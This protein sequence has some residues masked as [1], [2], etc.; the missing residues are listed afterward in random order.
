[1]SRLQLDAAV[2]QLRRLAGA[3]GPADLSD[4]Q[5]LDAFTRLRDEGAFATLVSRYSSLVMGVCRRALGHEQDAE[6][7]LQATFLVLARHAGAIRQPGSLAAFLHGVSYRVAMN[8]KRNLA[9]QRHKE[10]HGARSE[11]TPAAEE[12]SW[13]EVQALLDEEVQA[14]PEAFRRV[15]VLCCL[16]GL[17]KPEA[18]RQLGLKEGTVSSRLARA[19]KHLQERLEQRGVTLSTLMAA[20]DLGQSGARVSAATIRSTAGWAVAYAAGACASSAVPAR[21]AALADG[22]SVTMLSTKTKL[23][24][25]LLLL[26][27]LTAGLGVLLAPL[28]AQAP[29]SEGKT[30]TR[31]RK[32]KT[33]AKK[34]AKKPA[35][36]R[37]LVLDPSGNPVKGAGIYRV[38]RWLQGEQAGQPR[39]P[40]AETDAA[41]KFL[42]RQ[43]PRLSAD[44]S[45]RWM[46]VAPGF[47]PA[48]L[49][50]KAMTQTEVTFRLVKDEPVAGRVVSLEGKP[51]K[52]VTV[53][54][55]LLYVAAR[56][57]L[58]PCL[59]YLEEKGSKHFDDQFAHRVATAA[60]IPGLPARLTTDTAGR[61]RLSGVGRERVVGLEV[62]GPT[63]ETDFILIVT[64]SGKPLRVADSR[65]R[66]FPPLRVF[67]AKFDYAASP[68]Q[69]LVGTVRD[70][71]TG[72]PTAG[73]TIRMSPL[74]SATTKK[75]GTYRL[76]SVPG[77][78]FSGRVPSV[79]LLAEPPADQPYLPAVKQVRRGRPG[80]AMRVDFS[81]ARGVWAEG[82]VIDKKT[83]KPVRASITY[84]PD[85]RN[86][87]LKK[88]LDYEGRHRPPTS[89]QTRADG[90]FRLPVLL[91]PGVVAA[92]VP[93]HA[94]LEDESLSEEQRR[95]LV[96]P[97]G[98][99]LYAHAIA[100][101]D[102]RP[103]EVVKCDLRVDPGQTLACTLVDPNGKPVKGAHVRGL[104]GL[105]FWTSR[106]VP[107]AGLTFLALNPKKS[108]WVLVLHQAR[109]LGASLHI[110]PGV[111]E[112]F[113]IRLEPTATITG[114][115]LD[116]E[117]R[118][119]KRQELLVEYQAPGGNVISVHLPDVVRSDDEGRF[120]IQGLIPGLVYRISLYHAPRLSLGSA[121]H[122]LT[123]KSAHTKNVGDVKARPR[124]ED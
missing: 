26:A 121:L 12:L 71:A 51:I 72:K 47:G 122:G 23:T 17:S 117:G 96:M 87:Q 73:V 76:P 19:R 124:R 115:L 34:D 98:Y 112:P 32:E 69:P 105:D 123:L 43:A 9:R 46:A 37:G 86:A 31:P 80:E 82:K 54:P 5:L 94:Y 90:S 40:L 25:L 91:G 100:R 29:Q 65:D 107:G 7:A 61:F 116:P 89:A 18:A 59:K 56:E 63:I 35:E 77:L 14:L 20:V 74:L 79:G 38:S 81:L 48:F 70:L 55:I 83:G 106:P 44:S 22:V 41:G 103:G 92:W 6:D 36:L 104:T 78:L 3:A 101:I 58:G 95:Q 66:D 114:R 4:E 84:Y 30:T 113:V 24:A 120:R 50:R 88:F 21:L 60:G 64:R 109:Q 99:R 28:P 45:E 2:G 75:D 67:P 97:P 11:M 1:M 62:S 15:F 52:G 27:V 57:D 13:R 8:S 93:S 102:A 119:L 85:T 16:E 42:L 33:Q 68:G 110:K 118:P 39:P 53:R 10:Q 111:K 49:D 108:R